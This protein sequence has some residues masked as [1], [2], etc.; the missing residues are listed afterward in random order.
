MSDIFV[1]SDDVDF[2]LRAMK[3]GKVLYYLPTQ[4]L[5]TK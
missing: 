1:Y 5:C 3:A 2:M 4:K